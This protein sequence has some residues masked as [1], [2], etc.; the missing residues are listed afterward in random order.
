[1]EK[2]T[3]VMMTLAEALRRADL[4][5]GR[6]GEDRTR[7]IQVFTWRDDRKPD[8]DFAALIASADAAR[9]ELVALKTA[10][11]IANATT[12][13]EWEG[14]ERPLIELIQRQ[15]EMRG[16]IAYFETALKHGRRDT[17][18]EQEIAGEEPSGRIL[19]KKVPHVWAAAVSEPERVAKIRAMQD[20][21]QKLTNVI[22]AANGA[23]TF[24]WT[25][26]ATTPAESE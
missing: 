1:M 20:R 17:E 7:A 15:G 11:A 18:F 25:P 14:R 16:D 3:V 12:E 19:Y 26:P 8:F 22:N 23:T 13:V 4:L 9:E 10:I 24:D 6:F 2:A 21:L 5:K